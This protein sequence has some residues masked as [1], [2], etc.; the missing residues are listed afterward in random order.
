MLDEKSNFIVA[1]MALT[2]RFTD[3]FGISDRL[4]APAPFRH[5]NR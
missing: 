4:S 3:E 1:C 5:G 2:P